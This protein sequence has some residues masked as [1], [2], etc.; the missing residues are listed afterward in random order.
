MYLKLYS[1]KIGLFLFLLPNLSS[2]QN[3]NISSTN[4]TV[5]SIDLMSINTIVFDN[6][7]MEVS[8][9]DCGK[10]YFSIYYTEE[11]YFDQNVGL[12]EMTN[13]GVG[14]RLNPNPTADFVTINT[15]D[16]LT[17]NMVV[18]YN[19]Q[20]QIMDS[21]ELTSKKMVYDANLLSPDVYVITC[22]NYSLK[23]VKL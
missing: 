19:S 13:N 1:L 23:F 3:L 8:T 9:T 11:V 22:L 18:I 20:G 10:Q 5:N 16:D 21:F 17:G 15:D 14:M 12:E 7:N 6:G 2:A 4:G